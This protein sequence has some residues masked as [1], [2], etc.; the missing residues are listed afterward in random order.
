MAIPETKRNPT[1]QDSS[2]VNPLK[3]NHLT[4]YCN[5]LYDLG[6]PHCLGL[7]ISGKQVVCSTC[8]A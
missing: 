7:F 4:N 6:E 1:E 5:E 8:I 3:Q 2:F